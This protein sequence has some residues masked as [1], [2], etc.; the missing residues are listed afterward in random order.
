MR[1]PQPLL[2]ALLGGFFLASPTTALAQQDFAE[3]RKSPEGTELERAGAVFHRTQAEVRELRHIDVPGSE[4]QLLLWDEFSGGST[5]HH[6]AIS[7]DGNRIDAVRATNYE[8]QLRL[9][10][11]DPLVTT[12]DFSGSPFSSQVGLHIVQF[13]TQPLEVY[14]K[15]LEARGASLHGYVPYHAVLVRMSDTTLE[16][17]RELPF[18]RWVG[19][20]HPEYRLDEAILEGVRVGRLDEAR[21]VIRVIE[22]GPDMKELV[23]GVIRSM[24]GVI[25]HQPP[26]SFLLEATLTL[27]QLMVVASLDEVQFID[28]WGPPGTDMDKAREISG[29]NYVELN[30]GFTGQ[31]VRAEIMDTGIRTTHQGFTDNGGVLMHSSNSTSTSHGTSVTGIVFASGGFDPAARGG[32]PSVSSGGQIVF[33]AYTQVNDRLAHTMELVDPSLSYQCVFQTNSWGSS[34]TTSYNNTSAEMDEII[35]ESGL[36]ILQSQSNANSQSSR[37]QA[38]AKNIVSVG[39]IKHENTLTDADDVISG[40]SHGPAADGRIKPDLAHFYDN[41]YTTSSSCNDCTTSSFGGT[42]AATPITAGHF[43]IF[44]Q[45]WHEGVFG[46]NPTGATVFES[47]PQAETAKAAMINTAAQWRQDVST[48]IPRERQGWGR[49]DVRNLFDLRDQ[50]FVVDRE[51]ISNLQTRS[52]QVSVAPST[53]ALRAT[54]VYRDLPGTT[55]AVVHRVNDLDLRVTSPSGTIYWGNNGL[56]SGRWST[57]GGVANERDTVENVFVQSPQAGLWTIEVIGDDIN[58]DLPAYGGIPGNQGDFSLWVTGVEAECTGGANV[59]CTSKVTSQLCLPSISVS[60]TPSAT[61]GSGFE[62]TATGVIPN[63]PGLLFYGINGAASQPLPNGTRCVAFPAVR[64]PILQASPAGVACTSTISFDFNAWIATGN[65]PALTAG[66]TVN[67]QFWTRD[68]QDPSTSN[69]S[70]AVQ[71]T[72]CD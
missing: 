32:M 70:D 55:S 40:A 41:V 5:E 35:F 43:G 42:S 46:N 34:L 2:A 36:V 24:G 54:M 60:G 21:Y 68:P 13:V 49:V 6:Y 62:I 29:A 72:I 50:T 38:W 67:A 25:E 19:P 1:P 12:P 61:A 23:A 27:E 31:G 56:N 17:V 71:F 18:V 58:T 44:F 22:S 9:A 14:G 16:Q 30:T 53:P 33:A 28:P 26:S 10:Q 37:P 63:Q 20:F 66:V 7:L 48:W 4:V 11:F 65:H 59:Y 52:Y 8:L 57:S 47:R 39:G 3:I 69:L 45:L 15:Q 51:V 64:G